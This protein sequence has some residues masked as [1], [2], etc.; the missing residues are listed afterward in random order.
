M[1]ERS[2][3]SGPFL[4]KEE[5][6]AKLVEHIFKI[7][8]YFRRCLEKDQVLFSGSVKSGHL[9]NLYDLFNSN[10]NESLFEV[11]ERIPSSTGG[12]DAGTQEYVLNFMKHMLN[13]VEEY[14]VLMKES[15]TEES[16]ILETLAGIIS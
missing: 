1:A 12:R 2:M 4:S 16:K 15:D 9:G 7:I 6:E 13:E 11:A 5:K 3:S 14:I 8:E 10:R